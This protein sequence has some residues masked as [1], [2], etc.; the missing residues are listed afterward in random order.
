MSP[1]TPS[2][3]TVLTTNRSGWVWT[4]LVAAVGVF[5]AVDCLRRGYVGL[6]VSVIVWTLAVCWFVALVF[7]LPRLSM[8]DA[9]V[10]VRN[11]LVSVRVPWARLTEARSTLFLELQPDAGRAVKV[12]A[13]P[14]SAASRGRAAVRERMRRSDEPTVGNTLAEGLMA[15]RQLALGRL[16]SPESAAAAPAEPA[17]TKRFLAR[18]WAI[19]AVLLIL[20][21]AS[22]L[23]V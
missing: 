14:V 17:V 5:A 8:D 18:D 3:P 20:A 13:A 9:G 19:L 15:E 23:L 6:G 12:W 7:V 11:V 2:S 4:V 21:A 1:D 10:S 16:T 22:L